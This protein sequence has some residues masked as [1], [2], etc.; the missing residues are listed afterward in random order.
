MKKLFIVSIIA[1]GIVDLSFGQNDSMMLKFGI[2]ES[3]K[4]LDSIVQF[5]FSSEN[6]SI[7]WQKKETLYNPVNNV[8]TKMYYNWDREAS[9]WKRPDWKE[10][11]SFDERGNQIMRANYEFSLGR[12]I[13]RHSKYTWGFSANGYKTFEIRYEWESAWVPKRMTQYHYNDMDLLILTESS[14]WDVTLADWEVLWKKETT[15][16]ELGYMIREELYRKHGGEWLEAYSFS[17]YHYD[18]KGNLIY[19]YSQTGDLDSRYSSSYNSGTICFY[20]YDEFN[21]R[22][23]TEYQYWNRFLKEWYTGY[24]QTV[25]TK[26]NSDGEL[27]EEIIFRRRT[28]RNGHDYAYE[29]SKKRLSYFYNYEG[30]DEAVI[31]DTWDLKN[32]DWVLYH[33]TY[34]NFDDSRNLVESAAYQWDA[35][36]GKWVGG[37]WYRMWVDEMHTY[38]Y[39]RYGDET[40]DITYRWDPDI[41][42]WSP[43]WK[44]ERVFDQ[45]RDI[46]Q[47]ASSRWQP[48]TGD[49]FTWGKWYY[50]YESKAYPTQVIQTEE[51]V[52]SYYPNPTSG[53]INLSGLFKPTEVNIYSLQGQ[54]L[55]S[56]QIV[57]SA[58]DICDLPNG[59]YILN[60]TSGKDLLLHRVIIKE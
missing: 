4:R 32:E 9:C 2:E 12:W 47:R 41:L 42:V 19:S 11:Y 33:M 24:I 17:E 8:T 51:S 18:E 36:L 22:I 15:Y 55:K 59:A 23:Y 45:D 21:K 60:L 20:G 30:Y 40:R 37:R 57:D 49:W 58:I 31:E 53:I 1:F 44:N 14:N 13:G 16:N 3:H 26:Y 5:N 27:Y 56:F 52:V 50:Y 29:E 35:A 7:R 46:W 25:E 48:E 28:H 6:D 43:Y 38:K 39:N 10:E 54:L 34:R